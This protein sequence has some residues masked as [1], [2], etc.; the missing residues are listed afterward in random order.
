MTVRVQRKLPGTPAPRKR[1]VTE[2]Q[3]LTP[4]RPENKTAGNERDWIRT[5]RS[6]PA[7]QTA[8]PQVEGGVRIPLA[9]QHN[10]QAESYSL[11]S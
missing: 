1:L 3:L 5:R 11:V 4:S 10:P 7:V 9:P 6:E 2:S 8:F